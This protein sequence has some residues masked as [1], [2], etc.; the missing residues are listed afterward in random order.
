MTVL[1]QLRKVLLNSTPAS[2]VPASGVP[3]SG[4]PANNTYTLKDLSRAL[5]RSEKELPELLSSLERSLQRGEQL[6]TV[7]ACC[8]GCGF[9]FQER[10]RFSRPSRCPRC[11]SERITPARFSLL[12]R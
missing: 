9:E 1:Q 8:L 10:T 6:A 4:A 2:D 7:P 5:R 11:K 12:A 3:A